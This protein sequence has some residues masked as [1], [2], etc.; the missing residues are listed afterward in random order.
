MYENQEKQTMRL[1]T[2]PMNLY[3]RTNEN[4]RKTNRS[5]IDESVQK[6]T[7]LNGNGMYVR[8]RPNAMTRNPK[9]QIIELSK[10]MCCNPRISTTTNG[11]TSKKRHNVVNGRKLYVRI[12]R[13]LYQRYPKSKSH[14]LKGN[15]KLFALYLSLHIVNVGIIGVNREVWI[16]LS[17]QSSRKRML[18]I[19]KR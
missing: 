7:S 15:D 1:S 12:H 2:T 17:N 4:S 3:K 14:C 19:Q 6:R 18:N 13:L 10:L 11:S 5:I 9:V 16:K 8:N